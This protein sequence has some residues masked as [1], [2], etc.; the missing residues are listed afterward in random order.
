MENIYIRGLIERFYDAG[1]SIDEERELCR[2]LRE[3]EV[4]SEFSKDKDVILALC[5]DCEPVDIPC[6]FEERLEAM[7]ESLKDEEQ[8]GSTA[9]CTIE[10]KH[11]RVFKFTRILWRSVAAIAVVAIGFLF[12]DEEKHQPAGHDTVVAEISEED[13]FDNPQ[14]AMECFKAAF[15]ELQFALN[16]TQQ[17]ARGVRMMIE[18]TGLVSRKQIKKNI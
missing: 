2:Y 17:N 12:V 4:P 6:G 9:E 1:L 15:G 14:D 11:G 5:G 18:Q 16:A 8:Q 3:N 13:T 10:G 7:V